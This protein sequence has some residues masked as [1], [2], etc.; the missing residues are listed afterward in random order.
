MSPY[1]SH[2]GASASVTPRGRGR[3]IFKYPTEEPLDCTPIPCKLSALSRVAGGRVQKA[4]ANP[5]PH[6]KEFQSHIRRG[7]YE[8]LQM[9]YRSEPKGTCLG[10]IIHPVTKEGAYYIKDN[11]SGVVRPKTM[12]DDMYLNMTEAKLAEHRQRWEWEYGSSSSES[13]DSDDSDVEEYDG[14]LATTS[15]EDQDQIYVDPDDGYASDAVSSMTSEEDPDD[16]YESNKENVPPCDIGDDQDDH[17]GAGDQDDAGEDGYDSDDY[18]HE[19]EE[20]QD[21]EDGEESGDEED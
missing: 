6:E 18:Y 17:D 1:T 2:T 11:F 12:K 10:L 5:H 13:E 9:K 16:D 15:P 8:N 20:D 7:F 4:R 21:Q 3:T 14:S 19:E